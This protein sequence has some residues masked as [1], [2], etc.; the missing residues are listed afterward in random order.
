M[1]HSV[2]LSSDAFQTGPVER[3]KRDQKKE[4][5]VDEVTQALEA[6]SLARRSETS[7]HQIPS[8]HLE[9]LLFQPPLEQEEPRIPVN[10]PDAI[11]KWSQV[12]CKVGGDLSK[13]SSKW[14]E[15]IRTQG[16]NL[17]QLTLPGISLTQVQVKNLG[18]SFPNLKEIYTQHPTDEVL[19]EIVEAFKKLRFLKLDSCQKLTNSGLEVLKGLPRLRDLRLEQAKNITSG[20]QHL[21]TLVNLRVLIVLG[22]NPKKKDKRISDHQ[23]LHLQGFTQLE[24]LMIGKCQLKKHEE[25]IS[26]LISKMTK[27]QTLTLQDEDLLNVD[28]VIENRKPKTSPFIALRLL[29][30][31]PALSS[32]N[33][34]EAPKYTDESFAKYVE[35]LGPNHT[36]LC[37]TGMH[38]VTDRGFALFFQKE[39]PNLK[40]LELHGC[41]SLTPDCIHPLRDQFKS[42]Q[43]KQITLYGCG[44]ASG[45]KSPQFSL[46]AFKEEASLEKF[47][48]STRSKDYEVKDSTS[49]KAAKP[50][51]ESNTEVKEKKA[52]EID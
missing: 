20:L 25:T 9:T 10:S 43:L 28:H 2:K 1:I 24:T 47:L 5:G 27:L 31:H 50:K 13:L 15:H 37:I 22:S 19:G 40:E 3:D 29:Q 36:T 45:I 11:A 17:R 35:E 49:A 32:F 46:R 8:A 48:K 42:K 23:L 7:L 26:R 51:K 38:R 52:A 30:L 14:Q 41:K 39:F 21:A 4:D 12:I 34:I 18:G 33:G 44:F 6:A 16:K